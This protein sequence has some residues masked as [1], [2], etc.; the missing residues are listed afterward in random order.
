MLKQR[1]SSSTTRVEPESEIPSKFLQL[2]DIPASAGAIAVSRPMQWGEM[3]KGY[4]VN[5]ESALRPLLAS[6]GELVA[7]LSVKETQKYACYLAGQAKD[8]QLV[9]LIAFTF[10]LPELCVAIQIGLAAGQNTKSLL[11]IDPAW[12]QRPVIRWPTY[13]RCV[14]QASRCSLLQDHISKKSIWWLDGVLLQV[15]VSSMRR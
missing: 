9:V 12:A 8:G 1:R 10:D 13:A 3:F 6:G 5:A 7:L 11:T 4:D 15:R 14:L 2:E